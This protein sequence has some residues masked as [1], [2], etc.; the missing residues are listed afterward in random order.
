MGKDCGTCMPF[1]DTLDHRYPSKLLPVTA[2]NP[3]NY[4]RQA[5]FPA[6]G[7]FDFGG[8][9]SQAE[10]SHDSLGA[11]QVDARGLA[12]GRCEMGGEGHMV[13]ATLDLHLEGLDAVCEMD[14]KQ[15]D[16]LWRGQREP[17]HD[18]VKGVVSPGP[19]GQ[20]CQASC[21]M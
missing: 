4:N 11:A 20:L 2:G 21:A 18:S 17:R 5:P 13:E 12:E 1:P 3:R 14:R 10:R 15:N 8:E 19:W 9:I 6:D 7:G 16:C